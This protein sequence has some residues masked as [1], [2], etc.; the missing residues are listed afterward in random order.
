MSD[1][2]FY[3]LLER[4]SKCTCTRMGTCATTRTCVQ[5]IYSFCILLNKSHVYWYA[6]IVAV[7][8]SLGFQT[9]CHQIYDHSDFLAIVFGAFETQ[10]DIFKCGD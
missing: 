1:I 8:F 7:T 2:R 9:Y 4:L 6:Y 5:I 3:L 10:H